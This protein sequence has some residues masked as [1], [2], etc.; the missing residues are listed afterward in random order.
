MQKKRRILILTILHPLQSDSGEDHQQILKHCLGTEKSGSDSHIIPQGSQTFLMKRSGG[1]SESNHRNQH[2]PGV[3]W[4]QVWCNRQYSTSPRYI[5]VR[6]F[7]L[8][9]PG[10]TVDKS[11]PANAGETGLTPGQED[12]TRRCRAT[13]PVGQTTKRASSR[14]HRK[15]KATHR[16][17]RVVPRQHQRPSARPLIRSLITD[18]LIWWIRDARNR[19][20]LSMK[21]NHSENKKAREAF[22]FKR[23]KETRALLGTLSSSVVSD[24]L[25]PHGL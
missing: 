22:H 18:K 8:N 14:S 2:L 9:F 24:S 12:S 6:M 11:S 3:V 17:S 7:S 10:G 16:G 20:G 21:I 15:E 25:R 5:V 13:K 23:L 4:L 1:N 19:P